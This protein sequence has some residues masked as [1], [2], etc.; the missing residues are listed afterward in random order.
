MR[1]SSIWT[2]GRTNSSEKRLEPIP[3]LM[4][5]SGKPIAGVAFTPSIPR[6]T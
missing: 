4:A 1:N 2:P 3:L 6:K 5:E